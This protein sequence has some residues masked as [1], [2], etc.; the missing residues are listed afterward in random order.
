MEWY[1]EDTGQ[2][3]YYDPSN[4]WDIPPPGYDA[5]YTSSNGSDDG[6]AIVM[7]PYVVAEDRIPNIWDL[8]E[9]DVTAWGDPYEWPD[10][11][12]IVYL[13]PE[14][15]GGG[16]WAGVGNFLKNITATAESKPPSQQAQQLAQQ[17]AQ[18]KARGASQAEIN[19]LEAQL[20][21]LLGN[22]LGLILIAGTLALGVYAITRRR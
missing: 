11:G 15:E 2:W 10:D 7:D 3:E 19:S 17:I 16:F 14:D 6:G 20:R 18:A 22:P 4:T 12:T 8:Y 21:S 13:E 1:N 5:G 9:P